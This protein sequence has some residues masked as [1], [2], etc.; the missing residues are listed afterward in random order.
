M[1]PAVDA[2]PRSGD[3]RPPEDLARATFELL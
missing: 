2:D 1:P 3:L